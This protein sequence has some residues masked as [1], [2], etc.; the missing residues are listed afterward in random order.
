[1]YAWVKQAF[2]EKGGFVAIFCEWSN[3]LVW[4]PTVLAFI[5]STL[6]F[7]LTPSL[8]ANPYYMFGVMM[9]AG[10]Y[11]GAM[12]GMERCM[13]APRIPLAGLKYMKAILYL[14]IP[15]S[16]SFSG[17]PSSSSSSLLNDLARQAHPFP[18]PLAFSDS[19]SDA[20]FQ[21]LLCCPCLSG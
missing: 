16:E 17:F 15:S 10:I 3:N 8:A 18:A 4:F 9:L 13:G 14:R 6:A 20:L 7:A 2:G 12:Y 19:I 5:A 21:E 1:V 11:Y